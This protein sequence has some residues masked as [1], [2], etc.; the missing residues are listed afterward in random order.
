MTPLEYGRYSVALAATPLA[1]YK[2]ELFLT[3]LS[4]HA[5]CHARYNSE[6]A[7]VHTGVR[8]SLTYNLIV[9]K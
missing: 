2:H 8:T 1:L 6:M 9:R 4:K 7:R 5:P 3:V